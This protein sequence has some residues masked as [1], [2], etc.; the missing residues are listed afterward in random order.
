[1]ERK[2]PPPLSLALGILRTRQGWTQKQLS[3]ATGI[4]ATLLSDYERGRKTLTRE[5]LDS[6]L[7]TMGLQ[8]SRAL[9]GAMRFLQDEAAR[10]PEPPGPERRQIEETAAESGRM[11]SDFTRSLLTLWISRGQSLEA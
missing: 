1:M 10:E 6:L 3:A 7:R 4:P 2:I 8:P 5:R 9:K 11:M